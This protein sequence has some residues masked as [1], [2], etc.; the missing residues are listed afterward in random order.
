[1]A[2]RRSSRT[3]VVEFPEREAGA[4]LVEERAGPGDR[5]Y[6]TYNRP[7]DYVW[8]HGTGLIIIPQKSHRFSHNFRKETWTTSISHTR[9][10]HDLSHKNMKH[11]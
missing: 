9:T 4:V 1:M 11:N 10:V 8:S 6:S 5:W 7:R 2:S 3:L